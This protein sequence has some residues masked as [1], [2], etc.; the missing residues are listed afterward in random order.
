MLERLIRKENPENL[1]YGTVL[2]VEPANK[3]ALVQWRNMETLASYL[4]EDFPQLAEGE[5]VALGAAAGQV[6]VIRQ[7]ES[8]I[9]NQITLLEV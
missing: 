8:A 3:R 5:T 7:I 6:F 9:P 2:S 4:P 1:G